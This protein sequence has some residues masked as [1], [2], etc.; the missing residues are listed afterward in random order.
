MSCVRKPW[1]LLALAVI[2]VTILA[3]AASAAPVPTADVEDFDR[4][5]SSGH[6]YSTVADD[7]DRLFGF[8]RGY[9]H[10]SLGVDLAYT[11]NYKQV[12]TGEVSEWTTT[13]SPQILFAVPSVDKTF[14]TLNVAPGG[15]GWTQFMG[16]AANGF[17][18][19]LLYQA[20]IER[21]RDHDEDDVTR[22]FGL[23]MLQY[24]F[25]SGLTLEISD[26]YSRDYDDFSET[27]IG[28]RAEYDSNLTSLAAYYRISQKLSLQVDYDYFFIRYK[29]AIKE[30]EDRNDQTL[31]LTAYYRVMPKTRIFLQYQTIE[32]DYDKGTISDYRA[33]NIFAG[34]RFDATAKIR[35]HLKVGY[36]EVDPDTVAPIASDR[37]RYEDTLFE[38]ALNYDVTERTNV[39]LT[40]V[41]QV[42]TTVDR[43]HQ[44]VLS[45]ELN[46]ALRHKF[47]PKWS[48]LLGGG[49]RQEDYRV[50]NSNTSHT[51]DIFTFDAELRFK[52]RRW[53]DLVARYAYTDRDSE[54]D[55]K[56]FQSNQLFLT[57]TLAY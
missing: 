11:D 43:F 40:G 51:D 38:V 1:L 37:D 55:V 47:R 30:F 14:T 29:D 6:S 39:A 46:L 49:L 17:Q 26:V 2:A 7:S 41:R 25:D 21:N 27:R 33:Y 56:D 19:L 34:V 8:G 32:V 42:Q 48:A 5:Y 20:D 16:D 57:L 22:H 3:H 44:N 13:I 9:L 23:G 53:L 52:P 54:I 35:G 45:Q 24:A 18:S 12:D 15:S 28:K 31:S 36:G 50:D 10:P 4:P